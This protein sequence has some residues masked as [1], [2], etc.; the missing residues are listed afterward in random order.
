MNETRKDK[1][2]VWKNYFSMLAHAGLPWGLMAV[3]FVLSLLVAVLSLALGG[4]IAVVFQDHTPAREMIPEMW[5]LIAIIAAGVACMIAGSHLQGV[6]TARIDR[7]VQKYAV[8]R[9]FYLK[10]KDLE[11]ADTREF[12]TRLTDDTAKNSPF[13][14]EL[15]INEIP[16][17]FYIVAAIVSVSQVGEPSLV[18][19]MF[20][21][22][23]GIAGLA[24]VSGHITYR[25][26]NKI[27][28]R[29]AGVTARLAEKIDD[30]ELIKSYSAE[31]KEIA[32]GSRVLDELNAVRKEG[33]LIDHI[34]KFISNMI[35]FIDVVII[36][37]PPTLLMF[38]GA[39]DRAAY[40]AYLTI[41][42]RFE[43]YVKEHLQVW[44]SL[45]EAQGAT[46]RL[47]AVLDLDNEKDAAA[48]AAAASGDIVFTDVSFAYAEESILKDLSFTIERGKKTGIVGLSGSGKSTVLNL[49]ERFYEPDEGTICLGGQDIGTV[50][51]ASHR[52]RFA[53]LPQNAPA[54]SGSVREM[55]CW[56]ADR[57]YSDEEM[58]QALRDVLLYD[59]IIALGG[60]D[61]PIGHNG[62]NLSGGQRQKLGIAR[63]LL[64]D[65][66]I[67]LLDEATSALDPEAT[68]L[69]Q[70]KIDEK[71]AGKTQV[72]VAHDLSTIRNA[73]KILVLEQGKLVGQ[74]THE[75]LMRALPLYA[76]LVKGV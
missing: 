14:I 33:A 70:K 22:I 30:I 58:E 26:R 71:C 76:G 11:A 74:G 34:N 60:L 20:L 57:E 75:E 37:V 62:E 46:R 35:W 56:S 39:I 25:N 9:I 40:V 53:Y 61:R 8:S 2:Y 28:A 15:A 7:N 65:S 73:D 16:R 44:V 54:L 67:V 43:T 12:I 72:L 4:Q 69:I 24:F 55:L 59:D 1:P 50:D 32:A 10:T 27:Q 23:P 66:E 36:V 51:Y 3:C 5:K 68:A 64:S 63:M 21:L 31:E 13:L 47:S 52:S 18:G 19:A 48:G 29:L 42:L 45:K 17:L 41:A 6:V 38:S 49:I